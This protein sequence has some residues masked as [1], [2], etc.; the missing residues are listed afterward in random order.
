MWHEVLNYVKLFIYSDK[1]WSPSNSPKNVYD[2]TYQIMECRIIQRFSQ[3]CFSIKTCARSFH[4]WPF[5]YTGSLVFYSLTIDEYVMSN[6][7]LLL[8]LCKNVLL[9]YDSGEHNLISV[10]NLST[11]RLIFLLITFSASYTKELYSGFEE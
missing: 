8:Y 3:N 2:H 7:F 5:F 4:I 9:H 11:C 10:L 6:S 1:L